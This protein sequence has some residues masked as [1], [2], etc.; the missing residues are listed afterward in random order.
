MIITHAVGMRSCRCRQTSFI[1]MP[2]RLVINTKDTDTA[3]WTHAK[4]TGKGKK[5]KMN[6]EDKEVNAEEATQ[7]KT[8]VNIA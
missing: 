4:V 6:L 7:M 8:Q 5:A 2:S 3:C 1:E